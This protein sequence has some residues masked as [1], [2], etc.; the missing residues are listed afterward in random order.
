MEEIM[1]HFQ[2]TSWFEKSHGDSKA[3]VIDADNLMK[4]LRHED[5]ETYKKPTAKF[6]FHF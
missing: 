1:K 3:I 5:Y 4:V 2:E 6:T